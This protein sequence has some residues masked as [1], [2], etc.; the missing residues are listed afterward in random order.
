MTEACE[1][2]MGDCDETDE[3]NAGR[4]VATCPFC[5]LKYVDCSLDGYS[6]TIPAGGGVGKGILEDVFDQDLLTH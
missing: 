2:D 1:F 5:S 4:C 3:T 6:I